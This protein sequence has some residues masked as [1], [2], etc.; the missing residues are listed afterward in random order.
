MLTKRGFSK[1]NSA[2][3]F[4]GP[5]S[6]VDLGDSIKAEESFKMRAVVEARTYRGDHIVA[7]HPMGEPK[8][9]GCHWRNADTQ[10]IR[11]QLASLEPGFFLVVKGEFSLRPIQYEFASN[12]EYDPIF[13]IESRGRL[14]YSF[15]KHRWIERVRMEK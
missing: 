14:K 4:K 3:D 13:D 7:I 15:V 2:D 11:E 8:L 6:Y 9:A 5:M 10:F 1:L 12:P